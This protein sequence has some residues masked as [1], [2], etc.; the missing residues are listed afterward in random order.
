[1]AVNDEKMNKFY[2]A[3]NHYAEEQ[4]KKIEQEV[5]EFKRKELDEAEVEALTEAYRLIQK[6]MA[7]MRNRIFHEMAHREMDCR[8]ELLAKR[9]KISDDVFAR[10]REK[11]TE[12]SKKDEYALLLE[13]F[14]RELRDVFD[15]PGTVIRIKDDDRKY[16]E[17][18][19]KAFG[20]DCTFEIDASIRIGGIRVYNT[21]CGIMADNT[22][23]S[24]LEDQHE[25]FEENSGMAVV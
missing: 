3:I 15:K 23:D 19:K 16:E 13:K 1:M 17:L 8:R 5:L 4:R 9:Q 21:E 20:G 24:L 22:L 12:F 14:A 25:W 10:C 2:L 18:I 7:Q 6:E 11:L